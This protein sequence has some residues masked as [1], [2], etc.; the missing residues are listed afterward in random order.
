MKTEPL[1]HIVDYCQQRFS[2]SERR[3]CRVVRIAR[4]VNAYRSHRRPHTELRM[5]MR[6]IAAA[7]T[8]YGY[9]KIYV[10]LRREGYSLG[11][12][13]MRRLYGEEGLAL[14]YKASRR[15]SRARG[16]RPE[17]RPA[18]RANAVWS[19]DFVVDQLAWDPL[20]DADGDRR[21]YARVCS[22]SGRPAAQQQ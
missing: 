1:R 21:L 20:P 3:A 6:E 14:R 5:R 4:G 18:T 13:L 16:T 22:R 9:R 2:V 7:R 11:K 17:R 19:L 12:H 10:L 15:R 8:H